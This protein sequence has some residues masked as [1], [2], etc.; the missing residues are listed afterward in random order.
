MEML[1]ISFRNEKTS[2]HILRQNAM[3]LRGDTTYPEDERMR[4]GKA[5]HCNR[6]LPHMMVPEGCSESSSSGSSASPCSCRARNMSR[7]LGR[8]A[9]I[10]PGVDVRQGESM[11]DELTQVRLRNAAHR[12]DYKTDGCG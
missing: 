8:D 9:F 10:V 3:Q 2:A 5:E 6:E 12:L 4:L 7:W 11:L 1:L